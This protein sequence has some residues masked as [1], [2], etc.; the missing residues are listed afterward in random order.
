[1]VLGTNYLV[2]WTSM[3]QDGPWADVHGQF[4]LADGSHSGNEF[5]VNNP[6]LGNQLQP[7]VASDGV[8]QFLTVWSSYS[9]SSH[10]FDLFA[11]DYSLAGFVPAPATRHYGPPPPE[12]FIDIPPSSANGSPPN[13][14]IPSA[15]TLIFP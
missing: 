7:A 15:I 11:Q 9:A 6:A 12:V 2:V 5:P 1:S 3:G 8:G 4:L 10:S 14:T 13:T